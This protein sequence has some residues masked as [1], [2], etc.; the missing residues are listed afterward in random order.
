MPISRPKATA[1]TISVPFSARQWSIRHLGKLGFCDMRLDRNRRVRR[2][3]FPLDI[4]PDS[5]R[6]RA[7]SIPPSSADR[8]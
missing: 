1:S 7:A 2:P 6:K 5:G 8:R 3:G 4:L